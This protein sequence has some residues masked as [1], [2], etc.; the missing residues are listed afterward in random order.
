LSAS[1]FKIA[2]VGFNGKM[3]TSAHKLFSFRAPESDYTLQ[4]SPSGVSTPAPSS[5]AAP[6]PR[7]SSASRAA[8]S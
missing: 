7:S 6:S 2:A 1:G 5:W 8:S 3:T 4:L